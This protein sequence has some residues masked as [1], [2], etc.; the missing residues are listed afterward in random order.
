MAGP[1][2]LLSPTVR[3]SKPWKNGGGW[4]GLAVRPVP[5]GGS[6]LGGL[7]KARVPPAEVL[8]TVQQGGVGPPDSEEVLR[9][10]LLVSVD[11]D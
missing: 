7:P 5:P 11:E 9:S 2:G 10:H 6:P 1:T 8:V 4:G 3:Q